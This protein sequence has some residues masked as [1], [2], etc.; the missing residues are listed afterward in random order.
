[1]SEKRTQMPIKSCT[2]PNGKKGYKYGDSGKC[3][4][5]RKDALRQAAA[6]KA[7]QKRRGKEDY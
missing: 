5:S 2:L 7:S 3:Y 1:L 4:A 6:I